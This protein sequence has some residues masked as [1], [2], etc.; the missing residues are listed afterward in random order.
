VIILVCEQQF[1]A[2]LRGITDFVK[3]YA[4]YA[5][6]I[7][8]CYKHND[9]TACDLAVKYFSRLREIEEGLEEAIKE[10]GKCL[11]GK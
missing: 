7:H 5:T 1:K 10:L 3:E 6:E 4:N 8:A 9:E 2:V 11:E